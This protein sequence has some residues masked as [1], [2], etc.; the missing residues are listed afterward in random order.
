MKAKTNKKS[1]TNTAAELIKEAS[2]AIQRGDVLTFER[3]GSGSITRVYLDVAKLIDM[4]GVESDEDGEEIYMGPFPSVDNRLR[5]DAPYYVAAT[6]KEELMQAP[7]LTSDPQALTT[8]KETVWTAEHVGLTKDAGGKIVATT[9]DEAGGVTL[10]EAGTNP[11]KLYA[12]T[13]AG[14]GEPFTL[15]DTLN[16]MAFTYMIMRMVASTSDPATAEPDAMTLRYRAEF[17]QIMRATT[18]GRKTDKPI[19]LKN[20]KGKTV[21][22]VKGVE[23][24]LTL[25]ASDRKTFALLNKAATRLSQSGEYR[26]DG[27]TVCRVTLSVKETAELYGITEESARRRLRRDFKA[28]ANESVTARR[29][30]DWITVPVAGGRFGIR[31]DEAFFTISPDF[32][33]ALLS[34]EAPQVDVPPE[35]FSTDDANYRAAFQIGTKLYAHDNQ[36]AKPNGAPRDRMKLTTLLNAA[37][38]LPKAGTVGRHETEKIMGPFEATMDHLVSKGVLTAWDYCH[39]KGEPLTDEEQATIQTERD[40]GKP[41]PWSLAEGFL[42]TWELGRRYPAHEAARE[43]SR[44]KRREKV[45]GIKAAK[46]KEAKA[47]ERRIRGKMETME[48]KKRLKEK[49]AATESGE[50]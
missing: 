32:M 17:A 8:D 31:K 7:L 18:K 40:L 4:A 15:G 20:S 14:T 26:H 22:V 49:E 46:E 30:K 33:Q 48:A 43:I 44:E 24:A 41:T 42:V 25:K 37:T 47:S 38:E 9:P 5:A 27:E 45:M 35:L 34:P 39:E 13:K 10:A 3:C 29:G 23:D 50:K 36:N 2:E 6:S 28:I 1:G 11:D 16:A 19:I 12:L 21:V